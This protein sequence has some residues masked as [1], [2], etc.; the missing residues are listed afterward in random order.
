M[1]LEESSIVKGYWSLWASHIDAF[2]A[3]PAHVRAN[4]KTH[5]PKSH[6]RTPNTLNAATPCDL[7]LPGHSTQAPARYAV[8][9]MFM[10]TYK[11]G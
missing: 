5:V 4:P 9:C 10:H 1:G 2:E 6:G 8:A 3:L 7:H 11:S